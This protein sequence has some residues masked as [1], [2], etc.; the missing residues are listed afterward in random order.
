MKTNYA[1]SDI[2]GRTMDLSHDD[3]AAIIVCLEGVAKTMSQS[4]TLQYREMGQH[5]KELATD[6][7][8]TFGVIHQ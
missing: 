8:L 1:L 6:I 3:I 4:K 5:H 2:Y 7:R